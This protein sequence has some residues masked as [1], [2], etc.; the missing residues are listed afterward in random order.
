MPG[1]HP[2]PGEA[3]RAGGPLPPDH[4]PAAAPP[5]ADALPPGHPTAS[6]APPPPAPPAPAGGISGTIAIS[7][8]ASAKAG[9]GALVFV[10]VRPDGQTA[11]PPVAAKRLPAGP[12]PLAFTIGPQDSMMGLPWPD[13]ATLDVRLDSDGNAM[14]KDPSDPAARATGVSAGS[15][16]QVTLR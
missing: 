5:P 12:F 4:P 13:P 7:A 3:P 11:G 9:P 6:A 1:D 15:R 8:A 14:S 16:V 10:S 2:R